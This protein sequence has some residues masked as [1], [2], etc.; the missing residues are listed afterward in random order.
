[1][2]TL[3]QRLAQYICD[4]RFDRID[5]A[6]VKRT[7]QILAY[8]IGLAC[9]AVRDEHPEAGKAV[10]LALDLSEGGGHATLIGQSRKAS[11]VDAVFA[12]CSMMRAMGLDDVIFP[13]G[14]HA[15]LMTLP[16]ALGIGE[17]THASGA[18][19]ITA[20]VTGYEIMGKFGQFTW[21]LDPPRRPTQPFGSFGSIATAG[22]LL[23]LD[24]EQTVVALAYAA[25]TAMGLAEHDSGPV[26]HWYSLICRHAVTSAYS[27][28]AGAWGSPTVIEG[29]YGF[30]D[31]FLGSG[32]VDG[33]AIADSLGRDY[34]VM[35]SCEKRYP[36]TAL[37]QIPI[38]LM[39][40]MVVDQGLRAR[41]V[42]RIRITF[43]KERR[44]FSAG[45][46]LGPFANPGLAASSFAFQCA[47][48]LLDGE[49]DPSRYDD[50]ADPEIRRAIAAMS[51]DFVPDK[52]IRYT[53]IEVETR[54][55]A[56][57][58]REG[59]EFRFAPDQTRIVLE[60]DAAGVLPDA[61]IERLIELL[62][63]LENV[64]DVAD[65]TDC[66]SPD[67]ARN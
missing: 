22:K 24:H 18:D 64:A 46:E 23:G 36:G 11:L 16:V 43:P 3:T 44:R 33:D 14:I 1:M 35:E 47:M 5:P 41:D 27:A 57:L 9:R 60:R 15:G 50:F 37:N 25:H 55:G 59:D 21:G 12:N 56:R 62:D 8:H 40:S 38:E 61:R 32:P 48:L 66:L 34:A 10:A 13:S 49:Q 53:R 30:A 28:R 2:T 6:A 4:E 19:L 45:H 58:V 52:P 31:T 65:L 39:R 26:S 54:S 20:V 17:R 51:V 63:D 67:P 29:R 42:S 7:G